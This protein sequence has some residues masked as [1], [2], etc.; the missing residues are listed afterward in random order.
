MSV[1]T[2][3][4]LRA[5][6]RT[7]LPMLAPLW[8]S[9]GEPLLIRGE[10][11]FACGASADCDLVI[12]LEGVKPNHCSLH[13][14]SGVL[15]IE[16][17]EGPIWLNDLP[18]QSIAQTFEGDTLAIGPAVFRVESVGAEPRS[19][20]SEDLSFNVVNPRH[21]N[22][23][24]SVDLPAPALSSVNPTQDNAFRP[25]LDPSQ[26]EVLAKASALVAD[27][28]E[29]RR[30]RREIRASLDS[31]EKQ[32]V[33]LSGDMRNPALLP[34]AEESG[35]AN[36]EIENVLLT[37]RDFQSS[38]NDRA[39]LFGSLETRMQK[40]LE[41]LEKHELAV[42]KAEERFNQRLAEIQQSQEALAESHQQ[43]LK[44]EHALQ[45]R[46]S[47]VLRQEASL[48]ERIEQVDDAQAAC[49]ERERFSNEQAIQLE[50]SAQK[51]IQHESTLTAYEAELESKEQQLD[52]KL[53]ELDAREQQL[54]SNE[55]SVRAQQDEL[56]ERESEQASIR[57]ALQSELTSLEEL[58]TEY[59]GLA[60]DLARRE[61]EFEQK[62]TDA[63]QHANAEQD[64]IREELKAE[65]LEAK[66]LLDQQRSEIAEFSHLAN[67][68]EARASELRLELETLR[69]Q[70][71]DATAAAEDA[72]S[73]LTVAIA[74]EQE[75]SAKAAAVSGSVQELAAI[76]SERE[77]LMRERDQM[78][79]RRRN[80]DEQTA[81]L[82]EQQKDL[83]ARAA[84]LE[85]V[86]DE[87]AERTV[88]LET[89]ASEI[90]QQAESLR[91]ESE[92]AAEQHAQSSELNSVA[93]QQTIALQ[94]MADRLEDENRQL[95]EQLLL[96]QDQLEKQES[97]RA[98][99]SES[100]AA[101]RQLQSQIEEL[102]ADLL[103]REAIESSYAQEMQHLAA[104]RDALLEALKQMQA[105]F[106]N[107]HA[108]FSS[109][110]DSAEAL[111]ALKHAEE[112]ARSDEAAAQQQLAQTRNELDAANEQLA[113]DR[114][115]ITELESAIS[116]LQDSLAMLQA[117]QV[118][119]HDAN[120]LNS[121][122]QTSMDQ[123]SRLLEQ[124][125]AIRSDLESAL[126]EANARV[127]NMEE[128]LAT[129]DEELMISRQELEALAARSGEEAADIDEA[130]RQR[131]ETIQKLRNQLELLTEAMTSAES[132]ISEEALRIESRELD[133]RAQL[134]DKREADLKDRQQL[135]AQSEEELET[136]RRQ[137]V[138]ARQQLEIARAEIQ[139]A[140]QEFQSARPVEGSPA[141]S[142]ES[143]T[144]DFDEIHAASG[145]SESDSE[146]GRIGDVAPEV[147]SDAEHHADRLSE[148]DGDA[149]TFSR[150]ETV[151]LPESVDDLTHYGD[152]DSIVK[153]IT[154]MQE[155]TNRVER[156]KQDTVQLT[157][158]PHDFAKSAA[159]CQD[160]D[161]DTTDEETDG[162]AVGLLRTEL[163]S[164][165]GLAKNKE[166]S[167]ST[168]KNDQQYIDPSQPIADTGVAGVAIRFGE[169]DQ[170]LLENPVEPELSET[171]TPDF[172]ASYMEQLLSR[173][174][175]NAG[176]SLPSELKKSAGGNSQSSPPQSSN[177][178]EPRP[179]QQKSFID[180]YMSSD[181]AEAP[182][183]NLQED[184]SLEERIP[185]PRP[186]IDR[187]KLRESMDSFR[188][189]SAM[190]V[191]NALST[192]ARKK[193][194]SAMSARKVF[195]TTLGLLT[196]GQIGAYAA[197]GFWEPLLFVA[198]G[199]AFT[200]TA[201]EYFLKKAKIENQFVGAMAARPRKDE[202]SES[203]RPGLSTAN[204][205]EQVETLAMEEAA[206]VDAAVESSSTDQSAAVPEIDEPA[207]EQNLGDSD[208]FDLDRELR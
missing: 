36:Q 109:V 176:S 135:L 76:A 29:E 30:A 134:L 25:A 33:A 151:T 100:E 87:L 140:M 177:D 97:L 88:A 40:R 94:Q 23:D 11:A 182:E 116:E 83:A 111:E 6:G 65:L 82:D 21:R 3:K 7:S 80:L 46:E 144:S 143:A 9:A 103:N 153:T 132:S 60:A 98:E 89:R 45:E 203:E 164:L 191:E 138:E 91:L 105:Q 50:Q 200:G 37:L 1:T 145:R 26:V 149:A 192:A 110:E 20:F 198:T 95:D 54:L 205:D 193:Q 69:E 32:I 93:D 72:Q 148:F 204:A 17:L 104:E 186:K 5:A 169:A 27:S 202:E 56:Q 78:D 184:D 112:S 137:M 187:D 28:E 174:R 73:R 146:H 42:T 166:A 172:V 39:E 92:K 114:Q 163:A 185:A 201:V 199:L 55:Q 170:I 123:E 70:L 4:R 196:A 101:S 51:L 75:R 96:L 2:S 52:A 141:S 142:T 190:S 35:V 22:S 206:E 167:K 207:A 49:E 57:E 113:A 71:A 127:A 108:E 178:T 59:E 136:Q 179:F 84:E 13:Y 195:A 68:G 122:D 58:R 10:G 47:V 208:M 12:H 61:R 16:K 189:V 158:D 171:E 38:L 118:E 125:E 41:V 106:E 117:E 14:R 162:D 168:E 183:M 159:D 43:I 115:R 19:E 165:F 156:S 180:Q 67:V 81:R 154:A 119:M 150:A 8:T 53:Q 63:Q 175:S 24:N 18:V 48:R 155:N 34:K 194:R 74:A 31:L 129:R 128:T 147:E 64:A 161:P 157:G 139:V 130:L 44:A 121:N 181:L 79:R 62:Q 133:Q 173:S 66:Q 107:L 160:T 86:Q 15:S 126:H 90:E 152:S 197:I 120:E 102:K 124:V 188:N 77:S 85:Q 99:F 131:D